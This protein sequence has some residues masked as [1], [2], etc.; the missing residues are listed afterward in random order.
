MCSAAWIKDRYQP[1]KTD[2]SSRKGRSKGRE[3]TTT[4]TI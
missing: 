1:A 2:P 4:T 3:T